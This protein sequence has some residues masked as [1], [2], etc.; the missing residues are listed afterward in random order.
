MYIFPELSDGQGIFFVFSSFFLQLLTA[1]PQQ[2]SCILKSRA[3]STCAR[4]D[5]KCSCTDEPSKSIASACII[6]NCTIQE[7][8]TA[9]NT[10]AT[11]CGLPVRNV[12][13][14]FRRADRT[15]ISVSA[16]F[17][18]CRFSY[19]IF[20]MPQDLWWDD[21]SL[22]MT[23]CFSL[24][25]TVISDLGALKSGMGRDVWTLKLTDVVA[26][27][28]FHWIAGIMYFLDLMFLRLSLLFFFVRIFSVGKTPAVI[29]ATMIFN[30]LFGVT[31][32]IAMLFT[33]LPVSYIWEKYMKDDAIGTCSNN[34]ALI[35]AQAI[36][37]IALDFWMLSIPL[38]NIRKLQMPLSKKIATVPMFLVGFAAT[39]VGILRLMAIQQVGVTTAANPTM[40][41]M[42]I[43]LWSILELNVGI[44]CVCMPTL[45]LIFV[46][47]SPCL[48][49]AARKSILYSGSQKLGSRSNQG[50]GSSTRHDQEYAIKRQVSIN[51]RYSW[52]E[53]TENTKKPDIE[54]FDEVIVEADG[55]IVARPRVVASVN[56]MHS[57]DEVEL[58]ELDQRAGFRFNV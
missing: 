7:G 14:S 33:C 19:K 46:R 30:V 40:T 32:T 18:V 10:T 2:L 6:N 54:A 38:Y 48:G 51:Q 26:F 36:I 57:D 24:A 44:V 16:L 11:V 4:T 21:L 20:F 52:K 55:R 27:I 47:L 58:L 50:S 5:V 9:Q 35:W 29:Y 25:G 23:F 53:E 43:T 49:R 1:S 3:N 42:K 31:T 15:L 41:R 8:L 12:Q 45:R 13:E 17:I 37:G 39:I 22:L 28:R 34:T 56:G